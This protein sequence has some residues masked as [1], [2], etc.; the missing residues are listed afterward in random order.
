MEASSSW[1]GS[2]ENRLTPGEG[3]GDGQDI[4]AE[5]EAATQQS[6]ERRNWE[7]GN[8]ERLQEIL[9]GPPGI[10]AF[11]FDNT[12]IFNDLGEACMARLLL[13]GLVRADRE[14]F[15]RELKHPLITPAQESEIRVAWERGDRE[16]P[17]ATR[18]EFADTLWRCYERIADGAGLEAAYR[19]TRV[20]FGGYTERELGDL[21]RRVFETECAAPID[22]LTLPSGSTMNTGIRIYA[23]IRELIAELGE[24]GWRIRIVTA[25]PEPFIRAVIEHWDLA[26]AAVRGMRLQRG[27]DGE[28]LL[29]VIEEPMTYGEGKV[30]A[31]RDEGDLP[32]DFAAG[33][34]W[35]DYEMLLAAGRVLLID[36]GRPD[37]REAAKRQGF[38]IQRPFLP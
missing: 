25:S 9:A 6:M 34:S 31:L 15:W 30:E 13:D 37:L 2:R 22:L 17:E 33:D 5:F 23:E 20:L 12:L 10:A 7:A 24:R 11:D 36:R 16:S 38:M 18:L 1:R 4:A 14:E 26:P 32:L 21:A 28:I 8:F 27:D 29:P 35:T 3:R 19:W